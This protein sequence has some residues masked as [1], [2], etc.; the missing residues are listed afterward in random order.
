MKV[1]EI[2]VSTVASYLRLEISTDPLLVPILATSKS[3]IEG[4]TGIH[5]EAIT[6]E[7]TGNGTDNIFKLSKTPIIASGV[8]VKLNGVTKTITTDYTINAKEGKITFVVT[9]IENDVVEISFT[10]GLDAFEDFWIVVMVLCQ[11]M[12]DNRILAV[13]TENMNKV[14]KT[15]LDLHATNGLP[16]YEV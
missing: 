7:F 6:D 2:T 11:D 1:S 3:F 12:H 5:D 9:P 13:D 8:V 15:I 14:V 4:Y 16:S 10:Y